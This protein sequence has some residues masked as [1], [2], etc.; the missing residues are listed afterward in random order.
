MVESICSLHAICSGSSLNSQV[1][2]DSRVNGREQPDSTVRSEERQATV[3][4]RPPWLSRMVEQTE[5]SAG[6]CADE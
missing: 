4:T 5:I 3:P 2:R 6:A 1:V